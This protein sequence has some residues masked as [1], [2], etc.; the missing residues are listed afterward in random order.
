MTVLVSG[1]SIAGLSVAHQLAARG[2]EV[3]V[4][5]RAPALRRAGSPIDV[6]GEAL[7]VA[8]EMGIL[9]RVHEERVVNSGRTLF[10]T[11]VDATGSPVAALPNAEASDSDGDIEIARDRLVDILHE[12]IGDRAEFVYGDSV[13]SV[14]QSRDGVE[15]AFASGAGRRFDLVIG[16]DGIHSTVRRAVF[17]P[18]HEFRRHL[19]V[20]FSI[21]DLPTGSGVYGESLTYNSPGKMAG[22]SDF[23]TRTLGF[24]AF[25]SPEVAYD[26]HSL[27]E[28]KR[29]IQDAFA[30]ENGWRVGELLD[31][32]REASDLY[33]D[34]VSQVHMPS[35][36]SDRVV[37]VG[38]AAHAAALFS[39]RGTSLAMLGASLL[40]EELGAA[41]RPADHAAA[42]T[43]YE[44]RLRPHVERAQAGV[45]EARDLLV[46][47]TAA[48]LAAR[49]SRFPLL[50]A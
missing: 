30:A 17:G 7:R 45:P 48:E 47:S 6:R 2:H 1:A 12:A 26:H 40:G 14:R 42:F 5:E 43:A 49:N 18:E 16:A 13:T 10:T 29:L 38:D 4:V 39:G 32:V 41:N 44:R 11:F 25:R 24:L 23:G 31:A 34:S 15:V 36:S 20:Y 3:T 9:R 50:A 22:I 8:A 28:Q 35:W 37:L 21:V 27:D 46:P 33:F 19:G